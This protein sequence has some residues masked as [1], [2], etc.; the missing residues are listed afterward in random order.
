[1]KTILLF[2]ALFFSCSIFS[3][4]SI[5]GQIREME[6]KASLPFTN[7]TLKQKGEIIKGCAT[8]VNGYYEFKEVPKG[9]YDLVISYLGFE[10]ESRVISIKSREEIKS[11][12]QLHKGIALKEVLVIAE[13]TS[14][15]YCTSCSTECYFTRTNCRLTGCKVGI[16]EEAKTQKKD[17]TK[18]SIRE[19]SLFPNP[20]KGDLVKLMYT[21]G[22]LNSE[23]QVIISV[24]DLSGKM[25]FSN[26]YLLSAGRLELKLNNFMTVAPGNYFIRLEDGGHILT[27][28]LVIHK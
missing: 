2:I 1:M 9:V 20:S 8:D 10:T 23:E 7:V 13:R 12:V 14:L 17:E 24:F 15:F 25:I 6:S 18:L 28:K 11:D 27:R 5:K 4:S 21:N 22:D 3:Q 19:L 16:I 26:A